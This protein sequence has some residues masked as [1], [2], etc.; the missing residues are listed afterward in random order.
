MDTMVRIKH[1]L[2]EFTRL[3]GNPGRIFLQYTRWDYQFL[4]R[5]GLITAMADRILRMF[6]DVTGRHNHLM[7][8]RLSKTVMRY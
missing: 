5:F 6:S 4:E 7:P 2:E 3:F 1:S 8:G